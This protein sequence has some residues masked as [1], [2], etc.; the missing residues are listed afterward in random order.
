MRL[1]LST[2]TAAAFGQIF[3]DVSGVV[4]GGTVEAAATKLGLPVPH[5]SKV[6][7]VMPVTK[8]YATAGGVA[9]VMFGCLLA[10]TQLLWMD[11]G[12]ADRARRKQ[13]LETLFQSIMRGGNRL[14]HAQHCTL[15]LVDKGGEHLWS[16][17]VTGD[18]PGRDELRETFRRYDTGGEGYITPTELHDAL[19]KLGRRLTVDEAEEMIRG[20]KRRRQTEAE[21]AAAAAKKGEGKGGDDT[22]NQNA[23]KTKLVSIKEGESVLSV[24]RSKRSE[25]RWKKN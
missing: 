25:R 24:R 10:M 15:W 6:Q 20:V 22:E 7:R 9:G 1:G 21:K 19:A 11:L 23:R 14:V 2:L 16:R 18:A 12:K 17:G 3:S 13:E 4:F 8:F 5:L